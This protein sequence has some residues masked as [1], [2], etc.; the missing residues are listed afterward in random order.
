[1]CLRALRRSRQ[2]RPAG[3]PGTTLRTDHDDRSQT[4]GGNP[5]ASPPLALARAANPHPRPSGGTRIDSPGEGQTLGYRVADVPEQVRR[6]PRSRQ[7]RPAVGQRCLRCGG[8][9]TVAARPQPPC[10][11]NSITAGPQPA[12]RRNP[13]RPTEA[14]PDLGY[15]VA[16][17]PE[18]QRVCD[19]GDLA[20]ERDFAVAR[21]HGRRKP[22]QPGRHRPGSASTGRSGITG[23]PCTR[24]SP[25]LVAG[26]LKHIARLVQAIGRD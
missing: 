17:V 19:G 20:G 23:R 3:P 13:A 7:A 15:R 22:G 26:S 10:D 5:I 9:E 8:F 4:A 2:A 24:S 25:D 21:S 12:Y 14:G 18:R 1:M 6:L 16:D 11:P